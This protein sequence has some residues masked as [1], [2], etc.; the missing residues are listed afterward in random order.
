[1]KKLFNL[2]KK[3]DGV[4]MT[5]EEMQRLGELGKSIQQS[6]SCDINDNGIPCRTD[7]FCAV[8]DMVEYLSIHNF[9]FAGQDK[10]IEFYFDLD[11]RKMKKSEVSSRIEEMCSLTTN[12]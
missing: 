1:M 2:K 3:R 12:S 10:L 6:L 7:R 8:T 9:L 11:Y 4:G 5:S